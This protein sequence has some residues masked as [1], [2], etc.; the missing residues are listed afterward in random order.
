M[1]ICV[2]G[3]GYMGLPTALLFAKNGHNVVGFDISKE[4]INDLN[5]GKLPFDEK[6]LLELFESAKKR[7]KA[8]SD[9]KNT[10]E[11]EVYLVAVPTP[12]SNEKKCDLS[13]VE[14]AMNTILSVLSD[15]NTVILESTVRPRTTIDIVKPILDKSKVGYNLAY[16]SEKAI[17]GN[18]IYEMIHNDRII[19][20]IDPKSSDMVKKLYS[21]FVKGEIIVTDCTTAETVKLMENTYRDVNIALANE[22]L[23]LSSDLGI[24]A[25][26]AIALANHH[27]R[28]KIM[29]PGPGVGGHCIPVDPWFLTEVSDKAKLIKQ[30]RMINDSMPS[31]V[32]EKIEK[33]MKENNFKKVGLLGAAYK[34]NVDD[35]RESPTLYIAKLLSEKG[36]EFK[37]HD[38]FVKEF[39]VE[40]EKDLATV[41]E[42]ADCLVVVCDHNIYGDLHTNKVV[43]NTKNVRIKN[44]IVLGDN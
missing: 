24:N 11:A 44:S 19:G 4:R 12:I 34:K 5:K 21:S 9:V 6:G 26:E 37:I 38:P 30:A 25:W 13:Y 17:P 7:F 15:G 31:Y 33:I 28:V 16:V 20:G 23:K 40:I 3:L 22:F 32:V 10:K 35:A 27:P 2:V 8:T 18:T 42:W 14:S 43:L 36:I 29:H 39:K 1:K 41:T